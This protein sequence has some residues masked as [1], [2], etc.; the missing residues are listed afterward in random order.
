MWDRPERGDN[1]ADVS[2]E[3]TLGPRIPADARHVCEK[4]HRCRLSKQRRQ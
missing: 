3:L 2:A 1:V 4:W